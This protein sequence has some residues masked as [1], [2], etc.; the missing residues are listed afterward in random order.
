MKKMSFKKVIISLLVALLI[1]APS[2][3]L[4]TKFISSKDKAH[5]TFRE[6]KPVNTVTYPN[7]KF[8]VLSDVHFYDTS[9]GITGSAYEE[10]LKSDRKLLAESKEILNLAID[11]IIKSGVQFV[12]ISG[13]LT[14]DGELINHQQLAKNLTRL[15]SNGIKVYVVPGNHDVN[16]P[17]SYKYEGDKSI[18]VDNVSAEQFVDIYKDFGYGEAIEMD[19]G[20]QGNSSQEIS[21]REISSLSY[22]A[23]PIKNL[24][25]VA[26]DTCKSEENKSGEEEIVSGNL[27][28]EQGKWLEEV[29]KKANKQNKAVIVLQHHGIVEH[30]DGQSK[31]H[32]EY[33]IED[34]KDIGQ[35]L[36]SYDVRIAFSGH[37]H[38]QDIAKANFKENGFIY[39]IETGSLITAPCAIR[40]GTINSNKLEIKSENLVKKLRPGTDFA[41]KA[42]EFVNTTV[43][44]EA[45]KTLRKYFVTKK[46]AKYISS[47]VGAAFCA[48]Y[49]GDENPNDVPDFDKDKLNLW[50]RFI[51]SQQKYV[52]EGL[53]RDLAPSDNNVTIDLNIK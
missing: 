37:Y 2:T 8:A 3:A 6:D 14:K 42:E 39:D 30:W 53:W 46:D 29:L 27:T 28:K 10:C 40:Y 47:Y 25:I 12:L 49:K 7:A 4:I 45:F 13:D 21:S 33:L 35:M 16:N 1:L 41:N 50:S 15:T 32:P 26:L 34:Y 31:L 11:N 20:S 22:V 38:A 18:L 19:V 23:E 24:W 51:Y 44:L 17:L 43:E 9:L 52:I 36:A 48:H 5:Y